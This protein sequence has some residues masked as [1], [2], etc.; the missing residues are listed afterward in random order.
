MS[1]VFILG[2]MS[3]YHSL[4]LDGNFL[5]AIFLWIMVSHSM[6]MLFYCGFVLVIFL[7][8]NGNTREFLDD[9]ESVN[10]K[11][12]FDFWKSS[13]SLIKFSMEL[14]EEDRSILINQM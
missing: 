13:E 14:T 6:L 5:M 3:F 12:G 4:I 2:I 1:V 10:E 8:F 9:K 7:F 11:K